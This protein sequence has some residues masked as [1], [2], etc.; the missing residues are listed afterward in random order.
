[1]F[2]FTGELPQIIK[3]MKWFVTSYAFMLVTIVYSSI[4][5]HPSSFTPVPRRRLRPR[6]NAAHRPGGG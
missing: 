1:M 5:L 2:P 4:S 3:R 6:T